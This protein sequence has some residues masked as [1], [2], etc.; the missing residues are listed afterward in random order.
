LQQAEEGLARLGVEPLAV[1]FEDAAAARAYVAETGLRWPLL[2]DTERRLYH[3]YG[4]GKARLRHL[5]GPATLRAYWREA[6]LGQLP[7]LPRAD[8]RQQGGN[9]LIDPAGLVR[10]HH[11]GLGPADR[12][13]VHE[14]LAVRNAF[15]SRP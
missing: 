2:V 13:A 12:P 3:A 1:T 15:P 6:L 7:R 11:V 9:V 14:L 10:F 4:M 5:F 8:T